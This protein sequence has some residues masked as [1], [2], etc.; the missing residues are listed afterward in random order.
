MKKN[1]KNPEL[2][3]SAFDLENVVTTSVVSAQMSIENNE[4]FVAQIGDGDVAVKD[5]NVDFTF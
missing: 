5:W 2:K 3:I 1:F 4:T